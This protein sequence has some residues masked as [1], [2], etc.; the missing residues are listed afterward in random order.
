MELHTMGVGS[1]YTQ[2]D[3]QELARIL[4]GVGV[5]LSGQPRAGAPRWRAP[6]ITDGRRLVRVQS[7]P[8]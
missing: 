6:T 3:V 4:T 5:N 1:G 7:Q 8:P 2:K